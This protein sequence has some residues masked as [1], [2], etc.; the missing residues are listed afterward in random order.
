MSSSPTSA[1]SSTLSC[2]ADLLDPPASSARWQPQ[3]KQARA[4]KL[5]AQADELL[6]GGAAGGGKSYWLVQHVVDEV[7]RHPGNRGVIFR[8]VY[9]SLNR[10]I[11]PRVR[12]ALRG[13]GRYNETLHEAQFANGSVLELATL[14][15]EHDVDN[16]Q[17]PEYGVVAFEELTEFLESQY[18]HLL[19]RLRAPV[20]GVRPHAVATTNPGGVG[21]AW[22]KRRFVRPDPVDLPEGG[23][24]PAPF[25]VWRPRATP[26]NST[27]GHPPLS[28][29]FVPATL[30]DN[31]ALTE[32]DPGYRARLRANTS[33][34][35]RRAL[36]H[37]DW[38]AIDAVEGALWE[39]QWLDAWRVAEA[40]A[41]RLRVVAVDPS[42]GKQ[43]ADAYGV[44]VASL[45]EDGRVY[46]EGSY[47]WRKP[48]GELVDS[49]VRLLED[50]LADRLVVERNHGGAW[51]VEAFRAR[52]PH[53]SVT[54]V[55]ASEGKRTRAEPVAALFEP[56]EGAS[57]RACLVGHHPELE[58]QMTTFT[59]AA[60]E[61]SPD[62]LDACVW[63]VTSLVRNGPRKGARM[64]HVSGPRR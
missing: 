53:V 3:P 24:P 17:G 51:L 4:V 49:T 37:G 5:A 57:P 20:D 35:K 13:L 2:L 52:H 22:V 40:P 6:Y 25:E 50:T 59:G 29:C 28:R 23:S 56:L 33:R 60:G 14:Q 42:D 44:D 26:E 62:E 47:S 32:R 30:D 48:V 16:F 64:T 31:P 39:Q 8:R 46:V 55:W 10:T 9:P 61:R 1:P 27:G 36:E 43:G 18:L 11:V 12:A 38:D 21:H 54:T 34:A 41:S 7:V 15:R 45:G 63:A 19:G 58:Q